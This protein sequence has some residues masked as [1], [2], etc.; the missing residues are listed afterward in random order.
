MKTLRI[1]SFF[2]LIL[3]LFSTVSCGEEANNPS[4]SV[5][6]LPGGV[7]PEDEEKLIKQLS[8]RLDCMLYGS[9]VYSIE[10]GQD[11]KLTV[12]FEN[13]TLS[14]EEA[15][16]LCNRRDEPILVDAKG[17]TVLSREDWNGASMTLDAFSQN[18]SKNAYAI[19]LS[20]TAEGQKKILIR[21]GEILK[22]KE[23]TVTVKFG[24]ETLSTF[25]VK[26]RITGDTGLILTG[27]TVD[28]ARLGAAKLALPSLDFDLSPYK[29]LE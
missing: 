16:L 19:V 9:T 15:A 10:I 27:L 4:K 12:S 29:A 20:L 17:G 26:N 11:E 22:M 13:Y 25:T 8:A 18:D 3:L 5:F 21:S 6:S 1:L 2:F 28:E 14:D 24:S 7:S 23:N